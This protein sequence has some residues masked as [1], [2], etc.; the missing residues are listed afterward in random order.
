MEFM[1]HQI[2]ELRTCGRHVPPAGSPRKGEEGERLGNRRKR[3]DPSGDP[4]VGNTF[5][6]LSVVRVESDDF[7]WPVVV[8]GHAVLWELGETGGLVGLHDVDLAAG[9]HDE[10][11]L[12]H[13]GSD[14]GSGYWFPTPVGVG[15]G[16][17]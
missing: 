3:E 13:P 12:N 11:G 4:R 5:P 8:R 14:G 7:G 9:P 10:F 6:V 1:A 17:A 15:C 2:I 16:A